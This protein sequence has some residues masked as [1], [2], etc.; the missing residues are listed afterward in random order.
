MPEKE[1]WTLDEDGLRSLVRRFYD[2]ERRAQAAQF[3]ANKRHENNYIPPQVTI[4]EAQ[5]N[6]YAAYGGSSSA[7]DYAN[8]ASNA[9]AI[10]TGNFIANNDEGTGTRQ[11]RIIY[12]AT[13]HIWRPKGNYIYDNEEPVTVYNPGSLP[14]TAGGLVTAIRNGPMYMVTGRLSEHSHQSVTF[15]ITNNSSNP[16]VTS[17]GGG[18]RFIHENV[19]IVPQGNGA[20]H[21]STDDFAHC[22]GSHIYIHHPG[23]YQIS[24]G[25]NIHK[26]GTGDFDRTF[27]D[28]NSDTHTHTTPIHVELA[29]IK[30]FI[31]SFG[32][33]NDQWASIT[34]PETIA[35]VTIAGD[36][37]SSFKQTVEKTIHVS[38]TLDTDH[39][40]PYL[41]LN[42]A[43]VMAANGGG[44]SPYPG[45]T[46]NEAW[47]TITPTGGSGFGGNE[48]SGYN[49]FLGADGAFQWW[50]GGTEPNDF[51]EEG[52]V[53]P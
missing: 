8:A 53:I 28:S 36:V 19:T 16:T 47:I 40:Q 43:M 32:N 41:R 33:L 29:L 2:E 6:L 15:R 49:A 34:G 20:A 7:I 30:N 46:F 18:E 48:G 23:H 37:A 35:H 13:G 26:S 52:V 44:T 9:L 39:G 12:P 14:I 24:W 31:T 11:R 21:I 3:N 50:G 45:A 38:H 17:E 27:T 25:A 4:I 10:S 51:D 5:S 42:L 1:V 22:S